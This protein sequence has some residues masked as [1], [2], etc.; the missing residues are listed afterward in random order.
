MVKT[1]LTGLLLIASVAWAGIADAQDYLFRLTG[2]YTAQWTLPA[3]PVTSVSI[4]GL[5]FVVNDVRGTF[6]GI[7][8]SLADID[9]YNAAAGGGLEIDDPAQGDR[10][11]LISDGP[12]L[13][14]G[15]ELTPTFLT[16]SYALTQF[17][18]TGSY[19]LSIQA[20]A[21][22][23]EPA[24]WGLMILGF[25]LV[26]GVMRRTSTGRRAADGGVARAAG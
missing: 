2:S 24:S 9:F 18:G 19:T 23:P 7:S 11:V 1:A 25:G 12:Q 14:A 15:G 6:Q 26:G 16:G 20:I 21:A 17:E 3:T 13:Y 22:V 4:P 8:G 10:A 5:G